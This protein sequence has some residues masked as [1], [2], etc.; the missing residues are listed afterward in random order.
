MGPSLRPRQGIAFTILQTPPGSTYDPPKPQPIGPIRGSWRSDA[1]IPEDRSWFQRAADQGFLLGRGLETRWWKGQGGF[2]DYSNPEA[3]AWWHGLQQSLLEWG[4]DGWKLDGTDPYAVNWLWK[5]PIP[6]VRSH[7]G[8]I[9]NQ[10]HADPYHW[11]EYR[12]GL[13]H[14][15]GFVTPARWL[16]SPIPWS[17]PWGYVPVEDAPGR[18]RGDQSP[19]QD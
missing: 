1:A 4:V 8:L 14:N 19:R 6:C 17:R 9:S 3:R 18:S 10:T 5:I 11:S 2:I 7:Q 16:D 12:H 15:P 13:E